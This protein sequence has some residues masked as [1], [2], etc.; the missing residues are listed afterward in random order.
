MHVVYDKIAIDRLLLDGRMRTTLPWRIVASPSCVINKKTTHAWT[1]THKWISRLSHMLLQMLKMQ[2]I[3][4]YNGLLWELSR[5][6]ARKMPVGGSAPDMDALN[7]DSLPHWGV[8]GYNLRKKVL[9]FCAQNHVILCIL[10]V[11]RVIHYT[12]AQ[13]SFLYTKLYR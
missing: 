7:R 10:A 5:P 9:K 6:V 2:H 4:S 1:A 11:L 8:R 12:R 13:A 3:F